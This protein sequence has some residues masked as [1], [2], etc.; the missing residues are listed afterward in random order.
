[1]AVA[2][3]RGKFIVSSKSMPG[4]YYQIGKDM[5]CQCKG[6]RAHGHCRHQ[7]EVVEYIESG[8]TVDIARQGVDYGYTETM[9]KL[10]IYNPMRADRYGQ[11]LQIAKKVSS[12]QGMVFP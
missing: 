7:K 10:S 9:S 2:L 5:R 1:M 4:T 12:M 11:A 3:I 8:A 6:F